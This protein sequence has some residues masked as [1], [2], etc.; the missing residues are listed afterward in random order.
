MLYGYA[1]YIHRVKFCRREVL[2]MDNKGRATGGIDLAG[3]YG[4]IIY[5]H[6]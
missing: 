1:T 5:M 3:A 2:S 4:I 6:D